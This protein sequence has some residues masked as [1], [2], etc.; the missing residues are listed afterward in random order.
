MEVEVITMRSAGRGVAGHAYEQGF[1]PVLAPEML[2]RP[3]RWRLGRRIFV[4]SMSD[5]FGDFVPDEYVAAVFGVMAACPQH[6]FQVLTKRDDRLPRWFA[7]VER[8]MK[9][10]GIGR[11]GAQHHAH[12]FAV[13][14][15]QAEGHGLPVTVSSFTPSE[16]AGRRRGPSRTSG[17]ASPSRTGSTASPGSRTC[18]PRPRLCASSAS[19]RCSR[20]SASSTSPASTG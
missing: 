15:A 6:T 17:S 19:S 18:A 7:W 1:D 9:S 3:L 16:A 8:A 10:H 14:A 20:T 5:L 4:N 2:D 12:P 11:P 13:C